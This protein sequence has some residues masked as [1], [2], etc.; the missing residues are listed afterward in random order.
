VR[1]EL[2]ELL[3]QKGVEVLRPKGEDRRLRPEEEQ[4]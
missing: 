3:V 1:D 4:W 2:V